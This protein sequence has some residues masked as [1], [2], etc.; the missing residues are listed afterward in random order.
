MHRDGSGGW[1]SKLSPPLSRRE[2][3]RSGNPQAGRRGSQES[4]QDLPH[5]KWRAHRMRII[6]STLP[7]LLALIASCAS[8]LDPGSSTAGSLTI[9]NASESWLDVDIDGRRW[10]SGLSTNSLSHV[11]S[12]RTGLRQVG[13]ARGGAPPVTSTD[14]E[15]H[16]AY[17]ALAAA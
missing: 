4:S 6:P 7:A 10:V 3:Y 14:G 2:T 8:T 16:S 17:L 9:A 1:S 11:L 15:D 13:C 5:P 12:V